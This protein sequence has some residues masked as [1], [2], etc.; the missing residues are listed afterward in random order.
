MEF[1]KVNESGYNEAPKFGPSPNNP[2][3]EL[4]Q[5]SFEERCRKANYRPFNIED[6]ISDLE[7]LKKEPYI[8]QEQFEEIHHTIMDSLNISRYV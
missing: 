2:P 6:L 5:L 7:T 8:T 1:N 4:K 3:M